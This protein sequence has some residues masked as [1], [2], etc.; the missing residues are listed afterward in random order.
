MIE[1]QQLFSKAIKRQLKSDVP[2]GAYLSGG[3]DSG[4]IVAVAKKYVDLL[5]TFTCGMDLHSASG[6]EL[7]YD[8][9]EQAEFMSYSFNT[10]HY[11][12]VLKAGDMERCIHDLVYHIED[13][14]VGQS[15]PNYY[16]AKLA[17]KFVKVVLAGTGSDEIFGGYPWRYYQVDQCDDFEAY[18]D[19]YYKY[20]QRILHDDEI[21]GV[22]R[23]CYHE[24]GDYSTKEVF[25]SVFTE[26]ER[27]SAHKLRKEDYVNYSL[28]FEA[29]TFLR[30]LLIIEDKISM[31]FGLETRVPFLDN[32][33]VDFAESVPV[34]QKIRG[35]SNNRRLNENDPGTKVDRYYLN[36]SDGKLI[37]RQGL[38]KII[39]ETIINARKQGFSAPD[40][41]WF[42]GESI[43]YVSGIIGSN[44]SRI[45]DFLDKKS[46]E[47]LFF[48][49]VNGKVNRR[50][51]IWSIL[52]FEEY[53]RTF[54]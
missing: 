52:N 21:A 51:F 29:R 30:G 40:A 11:E 9:R 54:F 18:V 8:E 24:I 14:R 19:K 20:W 12:A 35:S 25:K 38:S 42:R 3:M 39:P 26:E 36:T 28:N 34:R 4:S 47:A 10:S 43:D 6:V 48:E 22:M 5:Q 44:T 49:H 46:V 31:A 7:F 53:L 27:A 2:L 50:L 41:S 16:A 33:L 23:P 15:Y 32:E 13:P 45:Y 17:S 37:L 1:F